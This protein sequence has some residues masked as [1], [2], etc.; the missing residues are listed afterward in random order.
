METQDIYEVWNKDGSGVLLE[1]HAR[2]WFCAG[3]GI[4]SILGGEVMVR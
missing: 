2:P 3:S 1:E 4:R